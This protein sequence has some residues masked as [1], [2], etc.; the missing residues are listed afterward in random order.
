MIGVDEGECA[1]KG[2]LQSDDP[3]QHERNQPDADGRARILNRDDLS[4]LAKD[5]FRQP[6]MSVIEFEFFDLRGR[7]RACLFTYR[8]MTHPKIPFANSFQ[9]RRAEAIGIRRAAIV[10][11]E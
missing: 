3:R 6:T 11:C 4:V 5:V 7:R 1:R 8:G 2:E 9:P 10:D